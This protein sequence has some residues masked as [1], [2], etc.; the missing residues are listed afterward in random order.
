VGRGDGSPGV[1]HQAAGADQVQL[2]AA[3]LDPRAPHR[4]T[5]ATADILAAGWASWTAEGGVQRARGLGLTTTQARRL[6]ACARLLGAVEAEGWPMPPPILGPADV[7]AHLAD[8]RC[9]QQERVVALYVDARHRPLERQTIAIGGLRASVVQPRDVIGP[10]LG[11]AAA[12]LVLAH[13]HPSGDTRPSPEDLEV[14]RQLAEAA[15][16][17][18]LEL[19]DHLV[20]SRTGYCSLKELGVI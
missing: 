16:V 17:F 13:N 1:T 7:L 19:L 14:T 3:L 11:L 8:I 10:A 15:R 2:L 6:S 12:G 20:V 4:L 9:G 5:A 18:G